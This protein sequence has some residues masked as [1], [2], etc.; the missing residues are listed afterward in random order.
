MRINGVHLCRNII[1][2]L[3]AKVNSKY[4]YSKITRLS[5]FTQVMKRPT[6]ILFYYM[7]YHDNHFDGIRTISK[8]FN[9]RNYCLSCEASYFTPC[10]HNANCKLR[11][12]NC[13]S[14]GPN[15]PCERSEKFSK[16]CP[17]CNKEFRNKTCY[18]THNLNNF[19]RKSKRCTKCKKIWNIDKHPQGH[20]CNEKFCFRCK[21]FHEEGSCFIQKYLP[22]NPKPFRIIAYDFESEQI[23]QHDYKQS[24]KQNVNFI[25]AKV[26]CTECITNNQWNSS[27]KKSCEICGENKTITWAPFNFFETEVD[28]HIITDS[29]LSDFTKWILYEQNNRFTSHTLLI[30]FSST[31]QPLLSHFSFASH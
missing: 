6:G 17:S 24:L 27:L 23:P 9:A 28:R 18:I 31:S 2:K 10:L 12:I 3:M 15:F 21:K 16:T 20:N 11:C 14:V 26:F 19:C 8:F 4:L 25:C 7:N 13:G 30:H 1:I 5:Q 22:K 29:P